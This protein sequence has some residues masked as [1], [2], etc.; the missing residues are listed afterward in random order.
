MDKQSTIGFILIG[1]VLVAWMWWMTPPPQAARPAG[2]DTTHQAAQHQQEQHAAQ[3]VA[4][5]APAANPA[6]TASGSLGKFFSSRSTG[7]EKVVVVNTDLYRAEITTRGGML[8][9]WELKKYRSWD[10]VAVQLIDF[11]KG[12]DLN[13]LFTSA[14]GRLVNTN[15][16]YFDTPGVP[17]GNYTLS[18]TDSVTVVLTLPLDEGRRIQKK[19]TFHNDSYNVGVDLAFT[20]MASAIS[21]YE[22]QVV[23]EH[24]LQYTERN[25]VDESSYAMAY[26]SSGG[27]LIEVDATKVGEPVKRDINGSTDW[28]ATRTKYFAAILMSEKG[29][30]QGGYVDGEHRTAPNNGTIEKYSLA[31]KMPLKSGNE[32]AHLNLFLGPLDIK[33]IKEMGNGIDQI[34]TLGAAWIIRP[35]AQYVMVPLFHLLH[36]VIPNY[37]W[38]IIAF[39]LIINV[40]L[41]PL[42]RM[43]RKSM[44]RMQQLQPL[45]EEIKQKYADNQE[46]QSQAIMNLYREYGVNPASGCLP[47]LLQMPILFAL[48]AVFRA[49]IDLRQ[50]GFMLWITD[51][52]IPDRILTLPFQIPFFNISEVSG[53]ALA[54]GITMF[55]SQKMTVTDPRQKAMVWMMPVLMTLMFNSLPSGLN[56]Y[57]FVFNLMGIL[58]QF[59]YNRNTN[60]EPLRKVDPK[61][62]SGGIL[63]R[64]AKD[65]PKLKQ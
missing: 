17:W 57:Y 41:T 65:M 9:K 20:G 61:K 51:L 55:V 50:A 48:Y 62:K 22:Y 8:R 25:S 45:M 18:G 2:T 42:S 21:N 28:V 49:A 32:T 33:I 60:E 52:S 37:G 29:T 24:G 34:M 59:W 13:L 3:P 12:G 40:A 19:L 39:A 11:D 64:L 54:M 47:L 23:W 36:M 27:E 44:K 6:D 10:S 1:V 31:L 5:P 53:L 16:L 26:A 4:A 7:E 43:Q 35:I 15:Q 30:A 63:A 46:K 38:V 14:D 56:L 58:Q